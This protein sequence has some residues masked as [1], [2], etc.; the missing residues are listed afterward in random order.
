MTFI[1]DRQEF[2]SNVYSCKSCTN[3]YDM[4]LYQLE[5]DAKIGMWM[6]NPGGELRKVFVSLDFYRKTKYFLN[7]FLNSLREAIERKKYVKQ[8]NP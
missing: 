6:Q 8:R 7:Y 2:Y 5:K 1:K 4:I 3:L